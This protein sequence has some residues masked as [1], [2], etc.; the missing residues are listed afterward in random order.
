[1]TWMIHVYFGP[2]ELGFILEPTNSKKSAASLQLSPFRVAG[3]AH[4]SPCSEY[5]RVSGHLGLRVQDSK[6]QNKEF[7]G[8]ASLGP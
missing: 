4:Y 2:L 3:L 6:P 5:V 7:K 1:M 8:P